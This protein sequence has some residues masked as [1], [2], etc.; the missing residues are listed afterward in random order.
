MG[1][2]HTMLGARFSRSKNQHSHCFQ[3]QM[4]HSIVDKDKPIGCLIHI[5]T[6]LSLI[7]NACIMLAIFEIIHIKNKA[8][9]PHVPSIK[10]FISPRNN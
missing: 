7:N 6:F 2:Q 9:V 10:S 4:N 5:L 1:C 3:T 8:G